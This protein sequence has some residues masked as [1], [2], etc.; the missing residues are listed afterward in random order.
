MMLK[1]FQQNLLTK[2]RKRERK[3]KRRKEKERK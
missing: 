1:M 2:E 3:K